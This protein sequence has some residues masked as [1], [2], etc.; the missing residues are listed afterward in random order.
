MLIVYL[1][2]FLW[3]GEMLNVCDIQLI[4]GTDFGD[5]NETLKT[6]GSPKHTFT[7]S[8]TG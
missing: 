7:V 1:R 4:I 5:F 8:M 3:N 6:Q 2:L